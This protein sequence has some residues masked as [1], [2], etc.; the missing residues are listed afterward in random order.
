MSGSRGTTPY[1]DIVPRGICFEDAMCLKYVSPSS[2]T[3]ERKESKK[4]RIKEKLHCQW[5]EQVSRINER[6]D[7]TGYSLNRN[8][9]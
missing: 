6:N 5:T 7:P 1:G 4:N 2:F 9:N 3:K 8:K